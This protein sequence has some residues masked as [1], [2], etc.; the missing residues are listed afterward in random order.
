[1][2]EDEVSE[3]MM[4]SKSSEEWN[5]NCDEVKRRCSGYPA[6]WYSAIISSGLAG[7]VTESFGSNAELQI[8]HFG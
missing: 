6:F 8:K 2:S 5:R 7:R 3:L 1:M 4:S